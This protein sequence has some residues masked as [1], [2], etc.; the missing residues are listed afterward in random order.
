MKKIH[1]GW[2][3][4]LVALV[5]LVLLKWKFFPAPKQTEDNKP[6]TA[7]VRVS[8]MVV[9]PTEF[10]DEVSV[11]GTVMPAEMVVL[12]PEMSGKITGIFF[13]EGSGVSA[14]Q[15]LI[16]LND[17]EWQAQRKKLKAQLTQANTDAERNRKLFEA[18]AISREVLEASQVNVEALQADLELNAAQIAKT[19]IKA[20]FAG[21]IGNRGV[22]VGATVNTATQIATLYQ[23]Q[24]LK[25][26][27]YL[28]SAFRQGLKEGS[29][30]F[31]KLSSGSVVNAR[32]Y[33]IEPSSDAVAGTFET[34]AS[35]K[36]TTEAQPGD[37]VTVL[38]RKTAP[39]PAMRIPAG[40]LLPVLKGNR[41]FVIKEGKAEPRDVTTGTRNDSSILILSGLQ[42]GDSLIT[43]GLMFVKPGIA[44]KVSPNKPS[45]P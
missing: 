38:V 40:A 24:S 39:A 16:K 5:L 23:N 28:P 34:R 1:K 8:A 26:K 29:E 13:Q 36:T 45:K 20:P 9:Q 25:V 30:L 3:I 12:Q 42:A 10:S 14:G 2:Y 17:A 21:K 27:C 32:I 18:K 35:L 22:S 41:V 33:S 44:V 4:F 7:F 11:S 19:E 6:K 31:V 37:M 43:G 15:L